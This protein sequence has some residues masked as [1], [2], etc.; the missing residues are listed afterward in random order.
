M[1]SGTY[2]LWS[3]VLSVLVAI[4]ASYVALD[5]GGRTRV[6]RGRAR[7]RW[8]A[9]G[10]VALGLGVW[11]MHYVGMLAFRLPVPVLYDLPIVIASLLVAVAAALVPLL[12]VSR[13]SP[14]TVDLLGGGVVMGTGIAA[15]HYTGMAAMHLPAHLEWNWPLV[16]LS[17]V[18][19]IVVS[20]VALHLTLRFRDALQEFDP[21]KIGSAALMGVAIAGMHYTGMAAAHFHPAAA[22]EMHAWIVH[23]PM[24]GIVGIAVGTLLILGLV[25]LLSRADRTLVAQSAKMQ[26][27]EERY[28]LIFERSLAGFYRST[29]DGRLLECNEAYA[30]IFGYD[31]PE[32]CV[33]HAVIGVY[34]DPRMRDVFVDALRELG[35][36]PDLES[37][38]RRK[39]GSPVWVLENA[40]LLYGRDGEPDTIEGCLL[41]ISRRK[42][43]DEALSRAVAAAEASNKAKSDFLANMSHEVRT[44]MNGVIGMAE[45]AL[46]TDLSAEQR[47]Y[48]EVIKI[49]ADSLL[50]VINDV[51][52]FSKIEAGKLDI[53]PIDFDLGATLDD[54]VR[55]LA[56][57]AHQKGLEL[58]FQIA[59]GVPKGLI[60]DPGRLRQI[61]VN[62][63]SNAIKFT[64][65]GEVVLRVTA[66]APVEGGAHIHFQVQDTGIGIPK[67]KQEAI[68]DAFVQADVSTT[69]RFGGTG[70]GLSI[71]AH[72]VMLMQ[73]RVWVE[74]E[75]G[76][77]STFHAMIPFG[78]RSADAPRTVP[79][80]LA[81][82]KGTTVLVVDDNATNRRILD[83]ILLNWGMKPT[84]VDGGRAALGALARAKQAGTPF[85]LVLLDFQMPEMDGFEVAERIKTDPELGAT[86]IMMLSSVGERGDGQRCRALGV[87]AYLTKPVRQSVLLDA[88]LMVFAQAATSPGGPQLVTRHSLREEQQRLRILLA[89]DNPVNQMVATKMLE[90]RGHTV[91]VAANGREAFAAVEKGGFDLV[92]MDVQMPEMDGR[93][94]TI[95]IRARER[96]AGGHIPIIAVTASAMRGD[97]E[98]CLAAGMDGYI[99]KPIKYEQLIE[100][101]EKVGHL[102]VVP[103]PGTEVLVPKRSRS[104]LELFLGDEEMLREVVE[105]Y[106]AGD[107]ALLRDLRKAVG[108]HATDEVA[109]LCHRLKG[110]AGAFEAMEI[111]DLA[112]KMERMAEQGDESGVAALVPDLEQAVSALRIEL[113]RAI[114]VAPTLT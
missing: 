99:T 60:G 71:C 23:V 92:L 38:L 8:L 103:S 15:M 58:A 109:R 13:E 104:L 10:A 110:S 69:R 39:D 16:V 20:L 34:Y 47:E 53:D 85:G 14:T 81:D 40:T 91:V 113:E 88:I 63:I 76:A 21:R 35:R 80:D 78:V 79:R 100:E 12:A 95:A 82:L 54:I 94:A 24:L 98:T 101:V 5:L 6:A 112:Q 50:S 28:R 44:P 68:F 48:L 18:I 22:P 77:G 114:G 19:A 64:E 102:P 108:R 87:A 41:D 51:L 25:A 55:S 45:L 49:S 33:R 7:A 111:C 73:G 97:R 96:V 46:Q 106:L 66:G 86:T 36:V 4:A 61:L 90:K 11:A 89:E 75:P 3:V 93:E 62:L 29:T 30:R 107:Q 67:E 74:S 42:E 1:L 84:L 37:Q 17:V 72:L 26:V 70:L 65:R 83:E 105:V 59:P 31:S 2:D 43:M 32:E 52:D 57:R 56:P 27:T 9:G